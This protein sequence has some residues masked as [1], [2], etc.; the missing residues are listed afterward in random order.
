MWRDLLELI[1]PSGANCHLCGKGAGQEDF[2]PGCLDQLAQIK[3]PFCARCGR[4]SLESNAFQECAR[5]KDISDSFTI[6]RA[7]GYYSGFLQ[8]AIH[9]FKYTGKRSLAKPLGRLMAK[10]IY[11]YQIFRQGQMIVPIP[12]YPDKL[13]ERGFNQSRLLAQEVA[14][15]LRV[16]LV[17]A[18]IR[19]RD[20]KPQSKL[21]R[22]ARR[23]NVADAFEVAFEAA[24]PAEGD[25]QAVSGKSIILVDDILTTGLSCHYGA[26]ALLEA[27]AKEVLIFTLATGTGGDKQ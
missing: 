22:Q 17:D 23:E 1:L 5:C 26:L 10:E 9:Q 16:P 18:L 19:K 8:Q 11:T 7:V 14:N 20:T 6:A 3:E 25:G 4:E 24:K 27:G 15:Y 13:R 2:C 12:L 21:C